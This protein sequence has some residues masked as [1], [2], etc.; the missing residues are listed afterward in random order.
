MS[1]RDKWKKRDCVLRYRAF[2]DELRLKGAKIP[3]DGAMIEFALP[4]PKSWSERKKARMDGQE[5]EQKPDLSNLI[6]SVEDALLADDSIIHTIAA[7]KTWA[8]T[9][10]I[11]IREWS[12]GDDWP[13]NN[14]EQ[15]Q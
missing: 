13:R 7:R 15:E 3:T 8:R 5:H 9:G 11:R 12:W 2:C 14:K 4:M 10:S 1:Q 6:K